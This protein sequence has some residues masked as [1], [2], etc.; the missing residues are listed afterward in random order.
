LSI[1]FLEND[2]DKVSY[3]VNLLTSRATGLAADTREFE[4]LRHELLSNSRIS[5]LMP[6]WLKQHRNLDTFWG[7]IKPKFGTYAERR[8]YISEVDKIGRR[9]DSNAALRRPAGWRAG[10]RRH[11]AFE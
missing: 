1:E 4:T 9:A 7:F 5:P 8:A 10:A 11:P 2:F 6:Q 3:L